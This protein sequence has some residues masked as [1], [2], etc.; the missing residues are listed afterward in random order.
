MTA[1]R[2]KPSPRVG[3]F[4]KPWQSGQFFTEM[5]SPVVTSS[6][7]DLSERRLTH[8]HFRDEDSSAVDSRPSGSLY[9]RYSASLLPLR[10]HRGDRRQPSP[11]IFWL[12]TS[13]PESNRGRRR[14]HTP[15][16]LPTFAWGDD[17]QSL[18]PLNSPKQ[19]PR[20]NFTAPKERTPWTLWGKCHL[21]C[22][23][24]HVWIARRIAR[25]QK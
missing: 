8:S 11:L 1:R 15:W 23:L 22:H 14:E 10:I 3:G 6:A 21:R 24:R 18:D 16:T 12:A 19:S 4:R 7:S 2:E 9:R 17:G 5:T 13:N 20:G 25:R